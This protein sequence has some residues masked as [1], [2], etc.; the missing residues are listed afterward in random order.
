MKVFNIK[1]THLLQSLVSGYNFRNPETESLHTV[2][3]N[4]KIYHRSPKTP[5]LKT[6]SPNFLVSTLWCKNPSSLQR[7]TATALPRRALWGRSRCCISNGPIARG[8]GGDPRRKDGHG[9]RWADGY[10]DE[11]L[12]ITHSK[13][14]LYGGSS[15][16]L[17]ESWNVGHD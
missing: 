17:V 7:Y 16:N 15:W 9:T 6:A 4:S 2:S 12:T 14:Q 8:G 10:S 13:L 11:G 1:M 5:L 3:S